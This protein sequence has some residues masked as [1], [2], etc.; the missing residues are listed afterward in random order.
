MDVTNS[1]PSFGHIWE[2]LVAGTVSIPF[3]STNEL[4]LSE[5]VVDPGN[6][7]IYVEQ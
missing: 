2:L 7:D 3:S 1:S 5:Q 6:K 4:V